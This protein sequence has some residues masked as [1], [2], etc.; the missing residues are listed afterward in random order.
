MPDVLSLAEAVTTGSVMYQLFKPMV[1]V[2]LTF[3]VGNTLS[4]QNV[5]DDETTRPALSIAWMSTAC[6]PSG[7]VCV[8]EPGKEIQFALSKMYSKRDRPDPG[9]GS[10]ADAVSVAALN[11]LF[12]PRVPFMPAVSV[13]FCMSTETV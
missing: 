3:A 9:I 8:P 1:P 12:E 6:F 5:L 10:D 7:K 13:G 2:S 11:Q 4:S